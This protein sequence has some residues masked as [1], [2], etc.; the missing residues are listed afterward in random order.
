LNEIEAQLERHRIVQAATPEHWTHAGD[1]GHV[2]N[3]LAE[4]ATFLGPVRA[5]SQTQPEEATQ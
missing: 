5:D 3:K 1:L 4:I 2:A